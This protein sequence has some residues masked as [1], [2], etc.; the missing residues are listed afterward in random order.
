[1]SESSSKI[2]Y[3][4][5]I[6]W[7]YSCFHSH[8]RQSGGNR[9]AGCRM[10]ALSAGHQ[11]FMSFSGQQQSVADH[12]LVTSVMLGFDWGVGF[13]LPISS[14]LDNCHIQAGAGREDRARECLVFRD[15]ENMW[16]S[17]FSQM[18]SNLFWKHGRQSNGRG[19]SFSHTLFFTPHSHS[20]WNI[21]H[22]RV[23]DFKVLLKLVCCVL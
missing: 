17:L 9:P 22:S 8:D 21:K 14:N 7:W 23:L 1:M 4:M 2:S 3:A 11:E 6:R 10:L 19:V 13:S 20:E 18:I 12:S 15:S 16:Q 5:C